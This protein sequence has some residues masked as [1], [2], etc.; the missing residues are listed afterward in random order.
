MSNEALLA[1]SN[2]QVKT[3]LTALEDVLKWFDRI[4]STFLPSDIFHKC[5]IAL[6]EGFT[7]AVR[8]AHRTLP[9]TTPIELE[10][11]VFS[12]WI[13]MR[14]W[15]WGEPFNLEKALETMSEMH[16][17]PLEHEGG[18]GLIFMS[19]LTD[20]LYYTRLDDQRNC[21]VMRKQIY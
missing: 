14:I 19:K 2:L 9:E 10:V 12:P 18:R 8:H 11:K 20:E 16:A 7:N 5:Q 15:D 13:E 6:T 21:L 3:S 4:T 1:Q 17:D